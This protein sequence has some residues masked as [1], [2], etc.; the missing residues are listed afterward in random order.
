VGPIHDG[1]QAR[2]NAFLK[3]DTQY[4]YLP[5]MVG[6]SACG[7]P[8]RVRVRRSGQIFEVGLRPEDG[9]WIEFSPFLVPG[10][11]ATLQVGVL[12]LNAA[13]QVAVGS[14]A[15]PQLW[16]PPPPSAEQPAK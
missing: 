8:M 12:S 11:P 13:D 15:D 1:N 9:E 3:V 7:K 6:D 14:F 10:C 4:A 2:F 5:P 16:L